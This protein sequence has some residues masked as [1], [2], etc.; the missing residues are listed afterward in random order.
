MFQFTDADG[1]DAVLT[2]PENGGPNPL[3][4]VNM[5]EESLVKRGVVLLS[6][7]SPTSSA[8]TF[9]N[10][11]KGGDEV[12]RQELLRQVAL[13]SLPQVESD[14]AT[15][16]ENKEEQE[17]TNTSASEPETETVEPE[18]EVAEEVFPAVGTKYVRCD[19]SLLSE[20]VFLSDVDQQDSLEHACSFTV[21]GA[22][23]DTTGSRQINVLDTANITNAMWGHGSPHSSCG[24]QMNVTGQGGH[25]NGPLP[26]C[27]AQGKALYAQQESGDEERGGCLNIDFVDPV[28]LVGM[29][30]LNVPEFG[31]VHVTVSRFWFH[32]VFLKS[33]VLFWFSN[34][35]SFLRCVDNGCGWTG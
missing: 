24:G 14:V 26:N 11:Y 31:S 20:G 23:G 16:E 13:A 15:L 32:L 17:S 18:G 19:F 9:L 28:D 22:E 35:S 5:T 34:N 1:V 4:I 25:V 12:E 3:W 8:L 29:G 7:C 6:V 2:S 27:M 10:Y 30:I 21:S 33:W